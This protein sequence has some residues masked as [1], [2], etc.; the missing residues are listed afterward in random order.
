MKTNN[1]KLSYAIAP[2]TMAV[3]LAILLLVSLTH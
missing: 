2:A 1:F 3:L